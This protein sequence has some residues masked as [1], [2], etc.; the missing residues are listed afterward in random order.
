MELHKRFKTDELILLFCLR[1]IINV[2]YIISICDSNNWIDSFC[3]KNKISYIRVND[4]SINNVKIIGSLLS[5]T[6]SILYVYMGGVEY[7]LLKAFLQDNTHLP[8]MIVTSF[9]YICGMV[10]SITVPYTQN[11]KSNNINYQGSSITALSNLLSKYNY[12]YLG[13]LRYAQG[14]IFLKENN[15]LSIQ[16]ESNIC[17]ILTL[18]NVV[19]GMKSRWDVVK[20]NFWVNIKPNYNNI[21]E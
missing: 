16:V 10:K 8:Q 12:K 1:N 5:P 11:P 13:V 17:E 14:V 20:H 3:K 18:P 9:N 2:T 6:P 7:W 19:F 4:K 21:S 15:S